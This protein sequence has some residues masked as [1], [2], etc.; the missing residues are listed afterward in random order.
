MSE[1]SE[2]PLQALLDPQLVFTGLEA[3]TLEEALAEMAHRLACAGVVRDPDAL[4]RR[5]LERERLGCTSL[6]AGIAIP[7]CKLK[8]LTRIVVAIG[9]S[10][11][12]IDF[13]AADGV[14]V[15]LIFL[16]LSPADAPSLHLQALARIS[17]VLRMPGVAEHLTRASGAE[18][19]LGALKEAE[20]SLL[21]AKG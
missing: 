2:G 21:V 20:T 11:A 8:E 13:H 12:G 19:I 3:T 9:S 7:H 10:R 4:A 16:I 17:R 1:T 6:G 15:T 14:P 18:E 5:L